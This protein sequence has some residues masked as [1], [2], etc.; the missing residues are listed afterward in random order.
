M[1]LFAKCQIWLEIANYPK[2]KQI[3]KVTHF[4]R[5]VFKPLNPY[6]LNILSNFYPYPSYFYKKWDWNHQLSKTPLQLRVFGCHFPGG[7]WNVVFGQPMKAWPLLPTLPRT[8]GIV[9]VRGRWEGRNP[10]LGG[11]NGMVIVR[12]QGCKFVPYTFSGTIYHRCYLRILNIGFQSLAAWFRAK[13]T[14]LGL[15]GSWVI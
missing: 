12:I 6:Y 3:F 11:E 5:A 2:V 1:F 9:L 8:G 7:W 15:L 10:L 14:I 4:Q 13:A